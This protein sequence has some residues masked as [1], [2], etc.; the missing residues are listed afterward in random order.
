MD[1][2]DNLIEKYLHKKLTLQEQYQLT[3]WLKE[4][5]NRD[6]LQKLEIYWKEYSVDVQDSEKRVKDKLFKR[7]EEEN[8]SRRGGGFNLTRNTLKIAAIILLCMTSV[9]SIHTLISTQNQ[10]V[11]D[12]VDKIEKQSKRGEKITIKLPDGSSVKLNSGSSIVYPE[13]FSGDERVVELKGEGFFEVKR[14]LEKPFIIKVN[15]AMIKVL[16]TS[17]NVNAIRSLN[18]VVV[19]VKTGQV[20]VSNQSENVSR[21]LNPNELVIFDNE[22]ER[23]EWKEISD[24]ELVFGWTNQ[25]LVFN[26]DR[27]NDIFNTLSNWY[28]VEFI[29]SRNI[30]NKRVFTSRYENP[31]LKSVLESLSY[32]YDFNYQINEKTILIK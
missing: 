28:G 20:K 16:G 13:R 3:K 11:V 24:Q 14:D 30:D 29:L 27:V 19:G 7:I 4:E 12:Q 21:I 18:Q 15:K 6:T 22:D 31:T 26:D 32:V 10:E 2:L 23:M 17:F 9:F 25:M 1:N 5:D 8:N